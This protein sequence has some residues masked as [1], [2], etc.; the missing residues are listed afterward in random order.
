[1]VAR[2]FLIAQLLLVLATALRPV[3]PRPP[4]AVAPSALS[5]LPLRS[6]DGTTAHTPPVAAAIAEANSASPCATWRLTLAVRE[7]NGPRIL[8]LKVSVEVS[9][10]SLKPLSPTVFFTDFV[11]GDDGV[12][13]AQEFPVGPG[14]WRLDGTTLAL[15]L[16]FPEAMARGEARLPA[17]RLYFVGELYTS[18]GLAV[19][20]EDH[21]KARKVMSAAERAVRESEG[22]NDRPKVWNEAAGRWERPERQNNAG[23]KALRK[24]ELARAK[25]EVERVV[26]R[27]VRRESLSFC[28]GAWP[29][30]DDSVYIRKEGK[31]STRPPSNGF[32]GKLLGGQKETLGTW[33]AEPVI[34]GQEGLYF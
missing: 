23:E 6:S 1:M 25:A 11:A 28:E 24:I 32:F 34:A 26:K 2:I 17:G 16:D 30:I 33:T 5:A 31:L 8:P 12:A 4:S 27:R 19:V 21:A 3:V 13:A 18:G 20:E 22:G 29:G 15:D 7:R 9:P 10:G 14:S